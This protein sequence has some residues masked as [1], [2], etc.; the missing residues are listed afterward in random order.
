MEEASGVRNVH[1]DTMTTLT[2]L[3]LLRQF[4]GHSGSG[5]ELETEI[6][7]EGRFEINI[8]LDVSKEGAMTA[9]LDMGSWRGQLTIV[10]IP[11]HD[12]GIMLRLF[13]FLLFCRCRHCA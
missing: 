7:A 2:T 6:V 10:P 12:I 13:W 1:V 8:V 3:V 5:R 11:E 9:Q 4:M